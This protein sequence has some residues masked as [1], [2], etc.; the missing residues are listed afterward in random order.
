MT[1]TTTTTKMWIVKSQWWKGKEI[2]RSIKASK[3]K[4]EANIEKIFRLYIVFE[5]Y[6][7]LPVT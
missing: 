5:I 1:M 4:G 3:I 6:S 7:Y 2:D